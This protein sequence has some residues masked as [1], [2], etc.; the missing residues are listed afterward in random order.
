MLQKYLVHMVE[1][2]DIDSTLQCS[3]ILFYIDLIDMS[4]AFEQV[5]LITI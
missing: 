5:V 3:W 4:I 2:S 1:Y